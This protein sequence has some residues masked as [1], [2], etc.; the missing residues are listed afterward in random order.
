MFPMIPI[1]KT[2]SPKAKP[3]AGESLPFGQYFTDHMFIMD[4][5]DGEGWINPR[6]E[7]YAPFLIDPSAMVFH[8]G[9]AVFE[10]LQ[11]YRCPDGSINLFRPLLN[12]ERINTSDERLVIPELDAEFCVHATKELVS[13]DRDWIPSGDSES[14]YIRPFVIA[15]DPFLGVR[16]SNTYRF[17]II[18][19]PSGAYYPQ[20]ID[21]VKIYVEDKYVRAVRGGT[22]FT[23]C[24]GNYASSLI[25][26][27]IA[28]K[29]GYVQVLWLDGIER[30]YIEEVG[31]MN[32]LFV[33]D[34]KLV[35]PVLN[36]SI[37]PG[38]TRRSCI[39]LAKSLGME[40]EERKISIDELIEA[41]KNGRL[42]EAF[43]SGT[44]A[45]ISPVGELKYEEH[46]ISINKSRIGPIA[47]LFYDTITGVQKGTVEDKL[48]WTTKV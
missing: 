22:G 31:S 39:E 16:P 23:K 21:P 2:T 45:V 34:G 14:L 19:S 4:Y 46:V 27:D 28:H 15:T 17:M 36:G 13:L 43:G 44:A 35:T 7:P 42:S 29:K 3:V 20:G 18:L 40:V 25:A 37:L 33:I 26:Q 11:A 48:G 8:Y 38:I 32:I 41:G 6:I 1:T 47:Q 5:V 9:Q 30:K 24:A 12:F 10:G